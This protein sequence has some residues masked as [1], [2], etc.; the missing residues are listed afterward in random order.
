[1]SKNEEIFRKAIFLENRHQFEEAAF[2]YEQLAKE[3][4]LTLEMLYALVQ[5]FRKTG[6]HGQVL[7][8]AKEALEKGG[9]LEKFIPPFIE[10]W[11]LTNGETE[12]LWSVYDQPGVRQRP[13]LCLPILQHLWK[14]G[15]HVYLEATHLYEVAEQLFMESLEYKDIYIDI[16][17]FLTK[18][19]IQ[20]KNFPQARFHLRKLLFLRLDQ[21]K[22]ADELF[23]F[24]VKLD[25][26]E[27]WWENDSLRNLALCLSEEN[28]DFFLTVQ[29]M[30]QRK[31]TK[32]ELV[33]FYQKTF[34]HPFLSEKQFLYVIY[35]KIILGETIFQQE[36]A[37]VE[38]F[39]EHWLAVKLA[40][41]INGIESYD[42]LRKTFIYHAD[43]EEAVR[44]FHQLEKRRAP[45]RR[46]LL[47]RVKVTVLGGGDK[48]GGSSI[49]VSVE[50][51]HILLDAGFHVG[52]EHVLPNYQ[53]MDKLNISL[54]EIDA[55]I[56]T[57]AHMDHSAAVP[58]VYRKCPKVP[59]YATEQTKKLMGVILAD[60]LKQCREEE[61]GF[62]EADLHASLE[63]IQCVHGTF[64]IPSKDSEWKVTF[65][66]AGHILGAV[67]VHLEIK[68]VSILYTGDFSIVDQK[69]IKG[70][71]LPPDLHVDILIIENTYGSMPTNSC[72]SREEQETL[73]IKQIEKVVDRGG[74]IL[75]PAFAL[76]RAQEIMLILQDHFR[77]RRF[78]PFFVYVDGLVVEVSKIYDFYLSQGDH[79]S[80]LFDKGIREAKSFYRNGKF[81]E[82]VERMLKVG[83][84]CIIASSGMLADGSASSRYAEKILVDSKNAI[85]F[86]GYLDEESPG[87]SLLQKRMETVELNHR[88]YPVKAEIYSI[89][90]SAH[91][92]R[93]EIMKTAISLNP[94]VIFLVHGEH[95][96]QYVAPRS[97]GVV[98]PTVFSL[99][100]NNLSI[101]VVATKNG[102]IYSFSKGELVEW[103]HNG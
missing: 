82:F 17:L 100:K 45:K 41:M 83:K 49:L 43:L 29:K 42:L 74:N 99:L 50:D 56:V 9:D 1:M 52:E 60:L 68:G 34:T 16:V 48:I 85:A 64:T 70:M 97:D 61:T 40:V 92:S 53:P 88:R 75:I 10:A 76:G 44:I 59:I 28:W 65:Y 37:N 55:L 47:D 101:P 27:E 102:T 80:V 58:Y 98:Y 57:H 79:P 21:S 35:G 77:Y 30:Y 39:H 4:S 86:S 23:V 69:T 33:R 84:N 12:E 90:L 24:S 87:H 38:K 72:M 14:R 15:E 95:E 8:K 3:K 13:R 19:E 78:L 18:L 103:K 89:R 46:P 81:D 11:E 93:E 25:L 6:N 62:S 91:A 32:D 20:A 26:L 51:H 67:A 2:Y 66:H 71:A 54:N 94:S 36:I 31:I 7:R 96:Q 22:R 73:L 5:Y 63:H